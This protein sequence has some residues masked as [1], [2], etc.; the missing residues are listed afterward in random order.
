MRSHLTAVEFR[1]MAAE[2]F[3]L[4][5]ADIELAANDGAEQILINRVEQVESGVAAT[6]QFHRL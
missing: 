5:A 1:Q 2:G 6:L 3:V 4:Q